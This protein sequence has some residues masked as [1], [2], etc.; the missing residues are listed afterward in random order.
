MSKASEIFNY[1]QDSLIQWK[2][3]TSNPTVNGEGFSADNVRNI[4]GSLPP[5]NEFDYV[6]IAPPIVNET[7]LTTGSRGVKQTT[8]TY[9]IDIYCKRLGMG[10]AGKRATL[11]AM[12]ENTD[13]ISRLFI[14]QGFLVTRPRADLNYSGNHTARQVMNITKTFIYQ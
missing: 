13:F 4:E 2:P 3:K 7:A 10:N 6:Y 12:E 14:E 9:V 5:T 8:H 1:L 11:Q